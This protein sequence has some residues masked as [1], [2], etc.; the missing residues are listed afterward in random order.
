M[1]S[2]FDLTS[3]DRVGMVK[4]DHGVLLVVLRT[5]RISSEFRSCSPSAKTAAAWLEEQAAPATPYQLFDGYHNVS[6]YVNPNHRQLSSTLPATVGVLEGT[7][8]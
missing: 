8:A 3:S 1:G 4:F 2:T 5:Q 7:A 6:L